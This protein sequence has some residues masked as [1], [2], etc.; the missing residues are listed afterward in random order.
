MLKIM[1]LTEVINNFSNTFVFLFAVFDFDL[2]TPH[3]QFLINQLVSNSFSHM[4]SVV[5]FHG[6]N[7]VIRGVVF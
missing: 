5:S 4:F 1:P 6:N 2:K 7:S 3:I